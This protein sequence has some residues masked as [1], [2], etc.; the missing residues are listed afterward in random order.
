MVV[1]QS[2][3]GWEGQNSQMNLHLVSQ[4]FFF[5]Y[6]S[7]ANYYKLSN[8][9]GHSV[10]ISQFLKVSSPHMVQLGLLLKGFSQDAN[11]QPGLGA[12][13]GLSGER[14]LTKSMALGRIQLFTGC[15]TQSLSFQLAFGPRMLP[16]VLS[17]GPPQHSSVAHHSQ[18][19]KQPVSKTE[20]TVLC[21]QI[22]EV[23]GH[24]LYQILQV[25]ANQCLPSNKGVDMKRHL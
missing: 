7:I 3:L 22:I 20:L 25:K 6:C 15:Q 11:H 4:L 10:I 13:W 23:I 9:K 1:G 2:E 16:Q 19:E 21:K 24:H 17:C 5:F 8:L 18:Q 12:Q 14:A